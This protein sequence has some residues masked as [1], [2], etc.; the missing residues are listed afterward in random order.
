MTDGQIGPFEWSG[1]TNWIPI[2]AIFGE[3]VSEPAS[4]K[5]VEVLRE[6]ELVIGRDVDTQNTFILFG[7]EALDAIV[8]SGETSQLWTLCIELDQDTEEPEMA[9][10]LMK[11]VKG[12]HNYQAGDEPNVD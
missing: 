10:A 1:D 11:V 3:D 9:C 4:P 6:A 2:H 8:L 12:S 5:V 7:R